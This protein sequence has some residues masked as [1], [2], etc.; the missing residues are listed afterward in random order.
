MNAD[1]REKC[2]ADAAGQADEHTIPIL[3]LLLERVRYR[4]PDAYSVVIG[5]EAMEAHLKQILG[6]IKTF[7]QSGNWLHSHKP[8][9]VLEFWKQED[10]ESFKAYFKTMKQDDRNMARLVSCLIRRFDSGASMEYQYGDMNGSHMFWDDFTQSEAIAAIVRLQ[11]TAAFAALPED[12]Q[13]DCAAFSLMDEHV[14]RVTHQAVLEIKSAWETSKK[15][16]N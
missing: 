11:S 2:I 1:M 14:S 13:L 10:A 12:V 6:K 3:V 4:N 7:S 16:E 9:P 15:E 5:D 8:L